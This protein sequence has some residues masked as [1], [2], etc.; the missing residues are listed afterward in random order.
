MDE[1]ELA[2]LVSRSMY[3][4]GLAEDQIGATKQYLNKFRGNIPSHAPAIETY[5]LE[6]F[7]DVQNVVGGDIKHIIGDLKRVA[8]IFEITLTEV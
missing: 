6:D 2:E 5:D 1:K 8:E 4:L 3:F 7:P